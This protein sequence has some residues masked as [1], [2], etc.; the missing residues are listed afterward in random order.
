MFVVGMMEWYFF[1]LCGEAVT[2]GRDVDECQW[3]DLLWE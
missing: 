2:W 3:Y 1:M